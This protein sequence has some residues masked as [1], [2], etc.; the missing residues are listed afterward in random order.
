MTVTSNTGQPLQAVTVAI[1]LH[2]LTMDHGTSSYEAIRL[3]PDLFEVEKASMGMAGSW[4]VSVLI[5]QPGT[6]TVQA[7]FEIE[8]N[9]PG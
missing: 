1:Q 2:H 7:V 9:V 4:Q 3:D 5:E 8:M 6:A